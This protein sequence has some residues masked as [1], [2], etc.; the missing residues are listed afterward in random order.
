[1]EKTIS[2]IFE[3]EEK[4]KLI[5]DRANQEKLRMHDEFEADLIKM[6]RE[7]NEENVK[8]INDYRTE[9]ENDMER[10]KN[11]LIHKCE[12]QLEDLE[13]LYHKSHK[14]FVERIFDGILQS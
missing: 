3:I 4:A 14:E 9:I 5:I 13:E 8:K 10:E 7:I 6:E 12:K 11:Q 2:K 1:M